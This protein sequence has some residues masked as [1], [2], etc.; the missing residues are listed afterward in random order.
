MSMTKHELDALA[1]AASQATAQLYL[2]PNA[3]NAIN[4]AAIHDPSLRGFFDDAELAGLLSKLKKTVNKVAKK[5]RTSPIIAQAAS[6]IPVVGPI[7]GNAMTA[8]QDKKAVEKQAEA[9]KAGEIP[10]PPVDLSQANFPQWATALAAQTT[11]AD[12]R[13]LTDAERAALLQRVTD[14]SQAAARQ[15]PPQT[16][17]VPMPSIPVPIQQAM[18]DQ[19]SSNMQMSL[20]IAGAVVLAGVLMSRR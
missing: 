20:I 7:V 13:P 12:G 19:K 15:V 2:G 9:M 1:Y 17:F 5:I 11:A 14:L 16:T 4:A 3:V 18:S 10:A 6:F 8:Y